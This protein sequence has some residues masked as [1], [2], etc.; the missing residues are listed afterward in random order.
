MQYSHEQDIIRLDIDPSNE[1]LEDRDVKPKFSFIIQLR[2]D[3]IAD[4]VIKVTNKIRKAV[5]I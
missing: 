5:I 3:L 1:Q 4:N 2:D